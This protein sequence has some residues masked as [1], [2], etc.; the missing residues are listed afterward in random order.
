MK[1]KK[2]NLLLMILCFFL[3]LL[4]SFYMRLQ[5]VFQIQAKTFFHEKV[6][7]EMMN[8]VKEIQ[9]PDN[10][11]LKGE[12]QIS[13]NTN[14]LNSWLIHVN[15]YL[16]H[17]MQDVYEASIP[18]GYFTGIVFFQNYGPNI[19]AAFLISNRIIARYD[20]KTTTL[21]INNAFIELILIVECKGDVLM[22]FEKNEL[23]IS[24][25]IP[26][27]LEYVQGEVPQIFP[28]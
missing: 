17:S 9:V 13:I 6:V 5:P 10:F 15:E 20:I 22:G 28:Y 8:S 21:G 11:I 18:I 3:I 19:T 14:E 2:K 25:K 27:A 4:I 7:S 12:K 16:N 1:I 26:L 24:E 23:S